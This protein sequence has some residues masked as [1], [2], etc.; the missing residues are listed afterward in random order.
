MASACASLS[1]TSFE[2]SIRFAMILYSCLQNVPVLREPRPRRI[3]AEK[4]GPDSSLAGS[5]HKQVSPQ[6]QDLSEKS[7]H[8]HSAPKVSPDSALL[9]NPTVR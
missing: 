8:R 9:S 4:R 1:P 2:T 3:A 5:V 6:R 7:A